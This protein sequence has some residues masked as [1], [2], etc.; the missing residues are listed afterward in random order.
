MRHKLL[1]R[2]RSRSRGAIS[3]P[4]SYRKTCPLRQRARGMPG[5]GRTH[6]PR[7]KRKC[8]RRSPQVQPRHPGIPR[9]I[10]YGL[11]ALSLGTGLIAPLGEPRETRLPHDLSTGRSGPHDFA[12]RRKCDRLSA[13]ADVHR[14]PLLRIVTIGRNAPLHHSGMA[15]MIVVICPTTQAYTP[16]ANWHDGQFA[17]TGDAGSEPRVRRSN[18]RV[19]SKAPSTSASFRFVK[20][21]CHRRIR[22]DRNPVQRVQPNVG[23]T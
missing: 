9:A 19:A 5:A 3:A 1:H 22:C 20:Q 15:E 23:F 11:Y 18:H 17:H 10:V 6:G 7:A 4:E 12:V 16:A 2:E 21:V 14:S 13:F 8:T